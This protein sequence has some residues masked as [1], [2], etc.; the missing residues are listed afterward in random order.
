MRAVRPILVSGAPVTV[1][2]PLPMARP[3]ASVISSGVAIAPQPV[4]SAPAI[5]A[6]AGEVLAELKDGIGTT[7]PGGSSRT[8]QPASPAITAATHAPRVHAL[9]LTRSRP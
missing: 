4:G 3:T 7:R 8:P 9:A 2:E 5:R 6:A 1:F